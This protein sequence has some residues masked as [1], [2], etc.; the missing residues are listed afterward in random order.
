ME[1]SNRKRKHKPGKGEREKLRREAEGNAVAVPLQVQKPSL[2]APVAVPGAGTGG[3]RSESRARSGTGGGAPAEVFAG[4]YAFHVDY[5]DHFET[6]LV[7][8][9][10]LQPALSSMVSGEANPVIFDPYFCQGRTRTY[11]QQLGYSRVI[12]RNVDFYTTESPPYDI[13]VTNPPYSG[14]HKQRLLTYLLGVQSPFCLLLPA[15]TATKSYWREFVAA[16]KPA[17]YSFLYLMPPQSYEYDHPEGTGKE[18]APFYSCWFLGGA[19]LNTA[20]DLARALVA[21]NPDLVI[22]DSVEAMVEQKFVTQKRLKP[23]R[24]KKQRVQAQAEGKV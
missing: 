22:L 21:A 17:G 4:A 1:E 3:A 6:P 20:K 12:N 14:D 2:A 23:S 10:D 15:Y 19:F 18:A 16:K 9:E 24:R 5:N 13:L 7:A 8:Y 11:L